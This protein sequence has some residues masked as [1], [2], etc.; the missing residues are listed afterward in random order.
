MNPI[1]GVTRKRVKTGMTMPAEVYRGSRGRDG[2]IGS[3]LRLLAQSDL[4]AAA[5]ARL[6]QHT[7][8]VDSPSVAVAAGDLVRSSGRIRLVSARP[9]SLDGGVLEDTLG[10]PGARL[11]CRR[12]GGWRRAAP[13]GGGRSPPRVVPDVS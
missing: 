3:C 11:Q 6:P 13:G 5:P 9:G 12:P 7:V 1:T 10:G 8:I 2:E 4:K